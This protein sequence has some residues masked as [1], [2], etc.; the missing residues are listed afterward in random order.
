MD[1]RIFD[2][3]ELKVVD[4]GIQEFF[5]KCTNFSRA[6]LPDLPTDPAAA[7]GARGSRGKS[8]GTKILQEC[9]TYRSDELERHT[10]PIIITSVHLQF[11][12]RVIPNSRNFFRRVT[13]F[14]RAHFPESTR[15]SSSNR[16]GARPAREP[17]QGCWCRFLVPIWAH[18]VLPCP[19]DSLS[20]PQLWD[21]G[22]LC[23]VVVVF[24]CVC[25]R[26]C[27]RVCFET[28]RKGQR[29]SCPATTSASVIGILERRSWTRP[30]VPIFSL[31]RLRLANRAPFI[32]P[33]P[34]F[35]T[36]LDRTHRRSGPS[37]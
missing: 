1:S 28:L 36:T 22:I 25:I 31:F 21:S 17:G 33:L 23:V 14:S 29:R 11:G 13:K 4:S 27:V 24:W 18:R 3:T 37:Q 20:S 32:P 8:S 9:A 34:R 19:A 5:Q 2:V 16:W 7:G 26:A 35:M 6:H 15:A 30:N 12:N 10:V